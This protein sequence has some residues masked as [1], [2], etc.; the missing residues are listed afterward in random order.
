MLKVGLTGGIGSGKSNALSI[1]RE[2]GISVIDADVVSRDVL[3]LYPE[4]ISKLKACFGEAFF[5]EKGEL[6]RRKLGDFIF[7]Y[8]HERKKLE[9]I[10]IPVIKTEINKRFGKYEKLDEKICVLDAPTLI[11]N[12]LDGDMD[13][14]ILVWV[15]K[16]NQ[17]KRVMERD[18][19][20]KEAALD[21]IN[22]QMNLDEKKNYVDFIV[23]SSGDFENTKAQI[24][25]IIRILSI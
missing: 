12:K 6:N 18:K 20:D 21:R 22:S 11:E 2:N 16:E 7:K 3:K 17:I 9:D 10:M 19:M 24:E 8:P 25:N 15:D 14:N 5:D 23:D 4:L 1:F 13:I